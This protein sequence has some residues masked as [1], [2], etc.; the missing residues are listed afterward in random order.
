[1]TLKGQNVQFY[2]AAA[3]YLNK[4]KSGLILFVVPDFTLV[5]V[6]VMVVVFSC[7]GLVQQHHTNPTN[8]STHSNQTKT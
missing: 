3:E 1:M 6:A 2:E 4:S 7:R 8:Q 5:L